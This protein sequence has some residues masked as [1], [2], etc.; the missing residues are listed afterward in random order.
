MP[1]EIVRPEN[2]ET[3]PATVEKDVKAQEAEQVP[4]SG[5]PTATPP[6]EPE[7]AESATTEENRL[8]DLKSLFAEELTEKAASE[9]TPTEEPETETTQAEGDK[10][11]APADPAAAEGDASKEE[12]PPVD[13]DP[14]ELT[15]ED[16][17]E[18]PRARKRIEGLSRR[19]KEAQ[20]EIEIGRA[21]KSLQKQSG[22]TDQETGV[23]LSVLAAIRRRDPA[24]IPM[25]EKSLEE[26]RTHAGIAPP[27]P[28]QDIPDVEPLTGALPD[29]LQN[30]VALGL[31]PLAQAQRDAENRT[32]RSKI[33][34]LKKT[35]AEKAAAAK[36]PA[37]KPAS[38]DAPPS[39]AAEV[40]VNSQINDWLTSQG[41]K[42]L[43]GH[44]K[45]LHGVLL[46]EAPGGDPSR[47]PVA[48]RIAEVKAAHRAILLEEAKTAPPKPPPKAPPAPLRQLGNR[49]PSTSAPPK[50][51]NG[52][53]LGDAFAEEVAASKRR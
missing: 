24:V 42:D 33:D 19:L 12:K 7:A 43:G 34:L 18:K 45:R 40:A 11:K 47:I 13:E 17:R 36:Q 31:I 25:I 53:T 51:G 2:E 4:A 1:G 41:V 16:K 10:P 46:K 48:S 15:D 30:S 27:E 29:D 22:L 50:K 3:A 52:F 44:Y 49:G 9:H 21:I 20:P 35:K 8:D 23:G 28:A 39:A 37:A 26:L 6:V 32:L 14:I 38:T 5:E